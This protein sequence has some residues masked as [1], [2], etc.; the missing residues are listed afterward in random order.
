MGESF[1]YIRVF[2]SLAHPHGL[3]LFVPDKLLS[4]EVAYQTVG[5]GLTKVLKD[6]KKSTWPCFPIPCDTYALDNFKHSLVEIEQLKAFSFPAILNRPCDPNDVEKYVTTHAKI[7]LF[8][9]EPDKFDD[10]FKMVPE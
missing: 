10:L 6:A 2:G 5:K 3:P 9:G 4:K 1:N 8:S 7:K